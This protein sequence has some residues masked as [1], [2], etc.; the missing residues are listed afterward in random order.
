VNLDL[1]LG[2]L[3]A[4]QS[5][6]AREYGRIGAQILPHT[7]MQP[8]DVCLCGFAIGGETAIDLRHMWHTYDDITR[9][10]WPELVFPPVSFS[11]SLFF[12]LE[13]VYYIDL[14]LFS[15]SGIPG[16]I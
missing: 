8:G 6:A 15:L 14:F 7:H 12:F 5:R 10:W 2:A 4:Q 1:F 3:L 13:L 16:N 9:A 11:L